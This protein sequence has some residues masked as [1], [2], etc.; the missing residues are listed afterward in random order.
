MIS[1]DVITLALI[2]K[3]GNINDCCSKPE[4]WHCKNVALDCIFVLRLLSGEEFG[5]VQTFSS[6]DSLD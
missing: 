4:P 2:G 5:K 3:K 6:Q 1:S